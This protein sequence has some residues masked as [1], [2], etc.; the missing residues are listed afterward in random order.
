MASK[1]LQVA[2]RLLAQTNE[3]QAEIVKAKATVAGLGDSAQVAGGKAA[4]GMG[5]AESASKRAKVSV[6]ALGDATTTAGNKAAA[7]MARAETAADKVDKALLRAR[8]QVAAFALAFFSVQG[9]R[10]LLAIADNAQNMA[11]RLDLA[12]DSNQELANA[13]AEVLRISQLT[14]T[15]IG[16]TTNLYAR[17]DGAL[18]S[19]N[20]TQAEVAA[21]TQ[22]IA[23]ALQVSGG[24]AAEMAGAVQQLAQG[25]AAGVLRGDEFNSV[26]EGGGRIMIALAKS[27]SVTRGELRGLAEDGLLTT[28]VISTALAEQADEIAREAAQMPL[29]FE[30]AATQFSN[31]VTVFIGDLDKT[32][33]ASARLAQVV[34]SLAQDFER[35]TG[36]AGDIASGIKFVANNADGL[37]TV[38]EAGTLA[39]GYYLFAFKALPAVMAAVS[40]AA[41]AIGTSLAAANIAAGAGIVTIAGSGGYAAAMTAL[42]GPITLVVGLLGTLTFKIYE[43]VTAMQQFEAQ[44]RIAAG[45]YEKATAKFERMSAL[46]A[47][48]GQR[49]NRGNSSFFDDL[50]SD[51]QL[52]KIDV[53]IKQAQRLDAILDGP[54]QRGVNRNY[55]KDV[56]ADLDLLRAQFL[57]IGGTAEKFDEVIGKNKGT[58]DVF[59]SRIKLLRN[60]FVEAG[61]S[62]VQ[63]NLKMSEA[64]VNSLKVAE[65]LVKEQQATKKSTEG[66][67]EAT[68]ADRDRAAAS[69]ELAKAIEDLSNAQ[70][71]AFNDGRD[72]GE[73][74]LRISQ[75]LSDELAGPSAQANTEYTRTL[76]ELDEV[77]KRINA[78]GPA[79][80]EQIEADTK[81]RLAAKAKLDK[82]L[83]DNNPVLQSAKRSSEAYARYWNDAFGDVT[84]TFSDG[85]ATALVDGTDSAAEQVK[86]NL[87]R[88][89]KTIISDLIQ[90]FLSA[91]IRIPIQ[92]QLTGIQG[93]L[94]GLQGGGL[95]GLSGGIGGLLS[96]ITGFGGGS[97][98]GAGGGILGAI[99]SLF[100]AL[101]SGLTS[102]VGTGGALG[103]FA[104]GLGIAA[105]SGFAGAA[106]FASASA[107][108]GSFAGA[109]GAAIPVV[110]A[111]FAVGS[112][113]ASGFKYKPTG[114]TGTRFTIDDAGVG[115][116]NIT[117]VRRSGFLGIGRN[118]KDRFSALTGDQAAVLEEVR[119]AAEQAGR[120]AAETAGRAFVG[121][122]AG[123]FERTVDKDGKVLK[124][125]GTA[126]GAVYQVPFEEFA[127]VLVAESAINQL[128]AVASEIA[129]QFRGQVDAIVNA[130]EFLV[131]AQALINRQ[132]GLFSG[133]NALQ[134][135]FDSVEQLAATGETLL[136]TYTRISANTALYDNA[137][138]LTG[139]TSTLARAAVVAFATEIADAAGGLDS[140]AQLYTRFF[141][142]AYTEQERGLARLAQAQ[143]ARDALLAQSG[144]APDVSLSAVRTALE[145]LLATGG[146][147]ARV[148]LLLQLADAIADV[149]EAATDAG[150]NVAEL[151][152]RMAEELS[153]SLSTLA[154]ITTDLD[155]RFT[156]L[157]RSGLS[158]FERGA[159]EIN[160]QL[161]EDV[162]LLQQTRNEMVKRGATTAQLAEVDRQLARA[163][164]FAAQS[165]VRAI[166]ALQAQGRSLV[167]QLRG[168]RAARLETLAQDFADAGVAAFGEIGQAA[169]AAYESQLASIR[170]IQEYLDGQSLSNTSSLT[171]TERF[172]EAQRQFAEA[173]ARG[174]LSR[175]TQLADQLLRESQAF[176]PSTFPQIEAYVRAA[177]QGVLA[178]GPI[179][180]P[181]GVGGFGS[182]GSNGTANPIDEAGETFAASQAELSL[183]IAEV[184]RQLIG[185][186]Q[187]SLGD[188]AATIGI[189]IA[190]LVEGLGINLENLTSGSVVSLANLARS[191]GVE[192]SEL[193]TEVGVDLGSLADAQSLLNDA[194]EAEIGL[195]PKGQA[196]QLQPLLS[197]LEAAADD[198]AGLARAQLALETAIAAI[199]GQAANS[200]QPYFDLI[201]PIDPLLS[202]DGTLRDG[203]KNVVDTLKFL[204]GIGPQPEGSFAVGNPFVSR[205]MIAQIHRGEAVI[206]AQTM[207]SLRRYGIPVAPAAATSTSN[208]L[209]P[210]ELARIRVAVERMDQNNIAATGQA[211]R[212]AVA[213]LRID[214]SGRMVMS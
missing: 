95:G 80:Q 103:A 213:A 10:E 29:T 117:Q 53:L 168:N 97:P 43:N 141:E 138:Q 204:G 23:Q 51:G 185:A 67:K 25:L 110:G 121:I 60:Q 59:T 12:T 146:D 132:Q 167:A 94:P 186:T 173:L 32:T 79:T 142:V 99:P 209:A 187:G 114:Q 45:E 182:V 50:N 208:N 162:A 151:A 40:G 154:G 86:Q 130:S 159:L 68:Q 30:R 200:L 88:I 129:E 157:A 120:A 90:A 148:V 72:A 65:A 47:Q 193:S 140:A 170:S 126:L 41:G 205:D 42:G 87:K 131:T 177:L 190:E 145:E 197:A 113:I 102:L 19:V 16:E 153:E 158:D 56:A 84:E 76:V 17:L 82:A 61:G 85:L 214:R 37:T 160:D 125:L 198:P 192:L 184:I 202:I 179:G 189:E 64:G 195:L 96:T 69:R 48:A 181:T 31:A 172:A 175:I 58:T 156:S 104:N 3:F 199:G 188:V 207:Q 212:A 119:A 1:E 211:S 93:G 112:F 52:K 152:A 20:A 169:N 49:L 22:T 6:D 194:L 106:S 11:A 163:H 124:E 206:D 191:L 161:L 46:A 139:Q 171:P 180:Q 81:A 78:A 108:V 176:Q 100:G 15:Q 39:L 71:A 13:Q 118:T 165:A 122:I 18:E 115:G 149:S 44:S 133:D 33:G 137:L 26:N 14:S 34:Q 123:S 63:F 136:Q 134:E 5:R 174:D 24:G 66:K 91:N 62:L 109:I 128:P 28:D 21:R 57:R 105:Q 4:A 155:A 135:A 27:L 196:D 83:A 73:E 107:S 166:E 89:T 54:R 8:G 143:A 35:G 55:Y 70:L 183:Q 201:D 116:Q 36:L 9:G 178:A 98:A 210:G 101:G 7:G 75:D 2:L 203:F 150:N 92:A 74:L 38:V 127:R 111:L 147:P 144:L 164:Q 77:M